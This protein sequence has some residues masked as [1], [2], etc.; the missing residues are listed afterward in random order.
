MNNNKNYQEIIEKRKATIQKKRDAKIAKK[1][2]IL[3]KINNDI[4]YLNKVKSAVEKRKDTISK[5]EFIKDLFN[6]GAAFGEEMKKG[7]NFNTSQSERETRKGERDALN[8]KFKLN[9]YSYS[10]LVKNK[11]N[12]GQIIFN[13][14]IFIYKLMYDNIFFTF[15]PMI[16]SYFRLG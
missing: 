4:E 15:Y 10:F 1:Q 7:H 3:D 13:S 2:V 11:K 6:A 14:Y 12:Y 5:K 16:T 9:K 8:G